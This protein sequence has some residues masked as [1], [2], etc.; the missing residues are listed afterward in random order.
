MHLLVTNPIHIINIALCTMVCLAYYT[1]NIVIQRFIL[2]SSWK[3]V[4]DSAWYAIFITNGYSLLLSIPVMPFVYGN[5]RIFFSIRL[6]SLFA[7]FNFLWQILFVST[8]YKSSWKDFFVSISLSNLA[9]WGVMAFVNYR[10]YKVL[11]QWV[12]YFFK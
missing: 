7:L 2:S 12:Y 1:T 8:Y 3:S 5:K 6:I 11:I 4:S 9:G 10:F